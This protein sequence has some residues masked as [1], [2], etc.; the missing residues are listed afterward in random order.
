MKI[1]QLA[2]KIQGKFLVD[3]DKQREISTGYCGDFLS[4][5]MGKAPANCAW[6]TV[7]TNL[8]IVAV[9]SLA[10]VAVIVVCEN[11]G[12][13]EQDVIERAK[14]QNLSIVSTNLDI[15]TAVMR[16]FDENSV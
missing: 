10:D 15:F 7:M 5:V 12:Q 16:G 1:E 9:G 8:N 11:N 13:I 4:F 3:G 2:K 14:Q 6:F